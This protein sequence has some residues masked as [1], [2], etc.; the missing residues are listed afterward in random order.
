MDRNIADLEREEFDVLVVGGG[1]VGAW[2]AREA[3]LQGWRTALIEASD[4]ASGASWNSLKI[5]HGGL[6]YLQRLQFRRMRES[7]R[8][9]ST[10]LRVAPHLIHPLPVLVPA[11]SSGLQRRFLLEAASRCNDVVSWDRNRHLADER[12][13]PGT[14]IISRDECLEMLPTR[15]TGE[16]TGGIIFHDAQMYAAERLVLEVVK[17][18]ASRGV[19]VANLVECRDRRQ[20]RDECGR[21]MVVDRMAEVE[22][23]ISARCLVN[24]TGASA[25]E[26]GETLTGRP[27]AGDLRYSVALNLVLDSMGH[28]VACT[29]PAR[30]SSPSTKLDVGKRQLLFVPWRGHT[31]V[32]TGHYTFTGDPQSQYTVGERHVDRF[33]EEVRSA[34]PDW[35]ISRDDVDLIHSGL[36]PETRGS[37]QHVDLLS[38]GRLID[39]GGES[40]NPVVTAISVKFT[41]ARVLAER[42]VRRVS[43]LLGTEFRNTGPSPPLRS[44]PASSLGD[45]VQRLE[46]QVDELV[47]GEVLEHLAR[48]YGAAS[49]DVLS[50]CASVPGGLDRLHPTSPTIAGQ[51]L[52]GYRNEMAHTLND[53]LERRTEL[54]PRGLIDTDVRRKAK[55]FVAHQDADLASW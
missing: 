42:V 50:L 37:E 43:Q 14:R 44:A 38:R 21:F 35:T 48:M 8:E 53:A 27:V 19:T 11:F 40:K 10:L 15:P 49:G 7:I 6:R 32:G 45:L 41:T 30:R 31:L 9:R 12:R 29:L 18:A 24:A 54:G 51:I 20:A 33:L 36:L 2:T 4:F 52:Y 3:A 46:E 25:L 5:V 39:D 28:D 23:E 13:L 47:E 22:F 16:V 26:L 1:I 34:A 55:A 17:D